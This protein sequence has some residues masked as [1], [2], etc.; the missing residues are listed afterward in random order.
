MV[1]AGQGSSRAA[2]VW[3]QRNMGNGSQS[4]WQPAC[5]HGQGN[6]KF[7]S[8][9]PFLHRN[10]SFP[11]F[12]AVGQPPN[13]LG[14]GTGTCWREARSLDVQRTSARPLS[15]TPVDRVPWPPTSAMVGNEKEIK[16]ANFPNPAFNP[17]NST[18]S[19]SSDS[20][21]RPSASYF[22]PQIWP[23]PPHPTHRDLKL[24]LSPLLSRQRAS[25]FRAFEASEAS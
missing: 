12:H 21:T 1:A 23:A 24:R 7:P 5:A 25:P 11:I 13:A 4:P 8:K 17:L 22:C 16:W 14:P 9:A 2:R 18:A 6:T 3:R 19:L 20:S 15:M 10:P